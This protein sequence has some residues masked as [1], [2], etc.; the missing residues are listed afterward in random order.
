MLLKDSYF[1]GSSG[2]R[3]LPINWCTSPMMIHKI[4]PSVDLFKLFFLC[5]DG[6]RAWVGIAEVDRTGDG[7][8]I[9]GRGRILF[10]TQFMFYNSELHRFCKIMS[11]AYGLLA[12]RNFKLSYIMISLHFMALGIYKRVVSI[13]LSVCVTIWGS[14]GIFSW[15][16]DNWNIFVL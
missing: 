16:H 3:K 6:D 14:T 9:T 11:V 5:L 12:I 10:L 4:T 8:E 13:S 7:V 2:I 1:L 15:T